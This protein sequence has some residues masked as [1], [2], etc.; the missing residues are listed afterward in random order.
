[1]KSK[2]KFPWITF[3]ILLVMLAVLLLTY[4]S[5]SLSNDQKAY[6]ALGFLVAIFGGMLVMIVNGIVKAV[7]NTRRYDEWRRTL[8]I[9]DETDEGRVTSILGDEVTIM[10]RTRKDLLYPPSTDEDY[11]NF[12]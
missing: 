6:V 10:K 3:S 12:K 4:N 11:F 8:K 9:G 1:M 2:S 5:N 7:R